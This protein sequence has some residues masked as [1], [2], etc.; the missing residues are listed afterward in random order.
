MLVAVLAVAC[1][2]E[3]PA[4]TA[5]PSPAST[6]TTTSAAATTTTAPA[7]T[8]AEADAAL[9]A[10]IVLF[11]EDL[12]PA[13]SSLPLD[14]AGSGFRPA[15]ASLSSALEPQ[16][17]A[18]DIVRFGLLGDFT[19]TYGSTAGLWIAVEAVAFA[20]PAGAGGYLA[21]WQEDLARGAADATGGS[22]LISFLPSADAT[23][24]DEAVR[25]RYT[26]SRDDPDHPEIEGVVR[27]V[28]AG[29]TLA[30]V[31]AAGEDPGR[32]VDILG[33][34]VEGRLLG[35]LSS[36]IP[37][38][39]PAGLGL[40]AAPTELL[41]SFA[42]EY[43]Y[44][45]ETAGGLG[46]FSIQATG[47]FRGPDRTSCLLAYTAG[48]EETVLSHLVAIGTRV[49]LEGA[50]GYQEVPLRHPSAL[51][52]LPLCPG[53]PLFWESTG[54]HRLPEATGTPDSLEGVAV[55]RADLA[56]DP[57]DLEALGYS[58]GRAARV[59]HYEVARAT[60]GGWVV[61]IDVEEETDLADARE[62]FGLADIAGAGDLPATIFTRLRL[63]RP[64]DA[65]IQVEPPL[66]A[67]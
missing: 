26:L 60:D 25:A 38:R 31:W 67:G 40:A 19:A 51:A 13:Y 24:A 43:S 39:D 50:N 34:L 46:G 11:P 47:E 52:D 6:T 56:A 9:L 64:D 58:A 4:S 18:D 20:D 53:H 62:L 3:P 54:F 23:A 15:G 65:A 36:E 59:T 42:F 22:D 61:E 1:S 21:D 17:E 32:V 16:D 14:P 63:S 37:S 44:G 33:P 10:S 8:A 5:A 30:W 7:T 49:W 35:V 57:G 55:L 48:E 28:R 12:P 2:T 66:T 27:V 41:A 45:I 29:A